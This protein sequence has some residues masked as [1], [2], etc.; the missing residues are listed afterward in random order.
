M[1]FFTK[2]NGDHLLNATTNKRSG[3]HLNSAREHMDGREPA[4]LGGNLSQSGGHNN[5]YL[6]RAFLIFS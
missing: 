3:P 5:G 1:Q 2:N 4:R 6:S